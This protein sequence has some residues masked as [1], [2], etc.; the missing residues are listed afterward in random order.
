MLIAEYAAVLERYKQKAGLTEL[1]PETMAAAEKR[2]ARGLAL[3]GEGQLPEALA[4]FNE[5]L[6][7]RLKGH[8]SGEVGRKAR[9]LVYGFQAMDFLKTKDVTYSVDKKAY[10]KYFRQFADQSRVYV[11]SEEERAADALAS[12][13]AA[14]VAAGV[15]LA[16]VAVF[17]A[18][19]LGR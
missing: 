1:D 19:A 7:K 8:P 10:D 14:L 6:Y 13:N 4:I 5:A 2:F 18:Y 12:R 15:V 16:P 11:A 9:H 3:M 17:A